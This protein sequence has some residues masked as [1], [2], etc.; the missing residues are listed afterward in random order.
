M[1]WPSGPMADQGLLLIDYQQAF[2]AEKMGPRNNPNAEQTAARLLAGFRLN[3]LPMFHIRHDSA[4]PASSLRTG[5]PGNALMA[6]AMPEPGETLIAKAVNSAFIGTSLEAQLLQKGICRLVVAGVTTDHCV[7]TSVRMAAN[8]G[9]AVTLA[10]DA[11]FTFD[12]QLPGGPAYPAQTV[13]DVELSILSGEFAEISS[14][15]TILSDLASP[16]R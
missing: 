10:A 2:H 5:A 3:G 4:D 8:L 7:S 12:R 13:H 11:C 9:F 14:V 1:R 16:S 15:D 6:F